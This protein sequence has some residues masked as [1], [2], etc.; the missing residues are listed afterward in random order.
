MHIP[1]LAKYDMQFQTAGSPFD[2][3]NVWPNHIFDA[4]AKLPKPPKTVAKASAGPN[5]VYVGY[6]LEKIGGAASASLAKTV[7]GLKD[8]PDVHVVIEG[9]ADPTGTPEANLALAEKRA[10]W[11]RDYLVSA[12]ID[13]S[14][15]EVISYG[16][17]R[18]K[19]GRSD[20]RNRRVAAIALTFAPCVCHSL[21]STLPSFASSRRSTVSP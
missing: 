10:E 8:N 6:N 4:A 2:P 3:E 13:A 1:K 15:L 11:V 18:L 9:H 21:D 14:R 12:G 5:E 19:Y 20:S 16:D 7:R 17:T